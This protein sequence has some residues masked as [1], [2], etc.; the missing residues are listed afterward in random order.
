MSIECKRFNSVNKG[1]CRGFADI[2]VQ[3]W[4][5]EIYGIVLN[6]KDGKRWISFPAKIYEK[7]GEKKFLPYFRFPNSEHYTKFCECVIKSI[8]EFIKKEKEK[9]PEEKNEEVF[10]QTDLF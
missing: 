9:K 4:G 8:E 7:N 1:S 10:N 6:E 2:F 3:K 5:I